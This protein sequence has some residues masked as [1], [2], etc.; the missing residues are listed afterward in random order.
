MEIEMSTD[1]LLARYGEQLETIQLKVDRME[2]GHVLR[3]YT[4]SQ[5]LK[6][7]EQVMK[8]LAAAKK[9]Y[10]TR[11][12]EIT[13]THLVK[14]GLI[15]PEDNCKFKT[16]IEYTTTRIPENIKKLKNHE[17]EL[18]KHTEIQRQ[19]QARLTKALGTE[20]P[21]KFKDVEKNA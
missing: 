16:L 1:K 13:E 17:N 14:P 11:F 20:L 5:V 7:K 4:D 12:E 21:N 6:A 10:T 8:S 9:E 2:E 15:G 18:E 19:F 3:E